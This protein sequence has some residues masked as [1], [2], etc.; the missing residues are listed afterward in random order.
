[1]IQM[2]FDITINEAEVIYLTLHIHHFEAQ[3]IRD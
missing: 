1:M 2:E 3:V